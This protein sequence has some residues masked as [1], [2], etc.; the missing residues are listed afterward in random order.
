[1]AGTVSGSSFDYGS[2]FRIK[3]EC[4]EFT[5]LNLVPSAGVVSGGDRFGFEASGFEC[6]DYDLRSRDFGVEGLGFR[7]WGLGFRV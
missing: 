7:V 2:G 5:W 4:L 6:R 3:P 1:M